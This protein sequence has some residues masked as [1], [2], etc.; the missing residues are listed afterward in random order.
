MPK[1]KLLLLFLSVSVYAKAQQDHDVLKQ[2]MIDSIKDIRMDEAALMYPR[3]RQFS[4][5][6]QE[7]LYGSIQSKLYGNAFFKGRFRSSKTT[8][9][10]N[11][12]IINRNNNTLVLSLGVIH[13]H[14]GIKE[15]VNYDTQHPFTDMTNYIPMISTGL[16]YNRR[17]TLFGHAVN[18]TASLNGLF[19]P[20]YSRR[21]FSFTGLISA[22]IIKTANS[23]LTGGMLI[24]IDPSSPIPASIFLSYFHKFRS[25]NMDLM[26]DLPYRVALRK[27]VSSRFSATGFGELSGNNAFFKSNNT[28]PTTLPQQLTY[29]SLEIKAG[30][31]FEYRFT[32]K[33]VLSFSGG[34]NAT[35]TSKIREQGEKPSNYFIKNNNGMAPYIQVGF[36]LLPFWKPFR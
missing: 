23:S 16:T 2:K 13:Q 4:I 3:I 5:T 30:M 34:M 31:L 26:V 18:F 27:A 10:M 22:P 9:N 21:Q 12:P 19:N 20:S 32:K 24:S 29:S 15:V 8:I 7:N 28:T 1:I 35:L 25:L 36:S 33:A 17:D 6:H 14:F 11:L